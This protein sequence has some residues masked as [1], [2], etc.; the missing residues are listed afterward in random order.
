MN[1]NIVHVY[2]TNDDEDELN[3]VCVSHRDHLTKHG[4]KDSS[5][6]GTHY[7]NAE[8]DVDNDTEAGTC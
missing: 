8:G 3:N 7:G 4:V 1:I 2:Q 5:S 6:W